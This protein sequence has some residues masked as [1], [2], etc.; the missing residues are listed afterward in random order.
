ML[1]A[2]KDGIPLPA[3]LLFALG[4]TLLFLATCL[5]MRRPVTWAWGL[6][7]GLVLSVLLEAWEIREAYGETG[8]GKRSVL[9]IALRHLGDV[10]LVNGPPLLFVLVARLLAA[11][12]A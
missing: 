8:V 1:R 5:V 10:A 2:I 3:P 9:G 6:L 4:G 12:G 7:P 11:R